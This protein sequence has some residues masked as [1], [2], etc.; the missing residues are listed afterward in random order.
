MTA[1]PIFITQA[2][3]GAAVAAQEKIRQLINLIEFLRQL[4][5]VA[6]VDETALSG[7][8]LALTEQQR[9]IWRAGA[10][11]GRS[12]AYNRSAQ[13]L[14][15][16]LQGELM[17][18]EPLPSK[19]LADLIGTLVYFRREAPAGWCQE[20][21]RRLDVAI[22]KSVP[23]AAWCPMCNDERQHVTGTHGDICCVCGR[24]HDPQPF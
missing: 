7:P 18:A 8:S 16:I 15:L 19:L 5:A 10:A 23:F 17:A 9:L 11:A 24:R 1:E 14:Q 3:A 12:V 2:Q 20:F 6:A 22:E 4:S 21:Q 13:Q